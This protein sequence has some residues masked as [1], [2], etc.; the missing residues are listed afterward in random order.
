MCVVA[1]SEGYPGSYEKGKVIQGITKAE[2]LGSTVFQAGTK[3]EG[4]TLLT[5]GGRVLGVTS[6]GK[7]FNKAIETVYGCLE[8]IDF[9][10]QYYRRDIGHRVR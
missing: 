8:A 3:L 5:D 2:A 10:G 7:D 6:R 9:S 1:A 4:D